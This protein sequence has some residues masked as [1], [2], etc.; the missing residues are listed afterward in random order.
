MTRHELETLWRCPACLSPMSVTVFA[1]RAG[2]I[3][4][5]WLRCACGASYPVIESIP[6]LFGD[7]W[8]QAGEFI[9]RY[10]Q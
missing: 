8:Q 6:R 1:E 5:G 9:Q 10:R 4:A 3:E 2:V 7:V